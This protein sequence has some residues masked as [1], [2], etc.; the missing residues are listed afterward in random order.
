M[1][2]QPGGM[3]MKNLP[4]SVELIHRRALKLA[5]RVH[6]FKRLYYYNLGIKDY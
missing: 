5:L 4:A 6:R 2:Q 3:T 1:H